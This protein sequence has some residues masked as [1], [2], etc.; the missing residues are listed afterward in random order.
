MQ[1]EPNAPE[2]S[3]GAA[4][5]SMSLLEHLDELRARLFR[6]VLGYFI[7]FLVCYSFH[8][9]VLAFLMAPIERHIE[10]GAIQNIHLPE[11]FVIKLKACGL[12]AVFVAAPWILLQVWGFIAPGMHR[13]EKR[14]VWPFIFFGSLFFAAGGAFGYMVALPAAVKWLL[15]MG[16]PYETNITLRSAFGF[17]TMLLLGMGAVFQLPIV[18][19]FL[20]RLGLVT[21]AFLMKN[22]RYAVLIMAI[23]AAVITPSGDWFTMSIVAGP[24]IVL[25]LLGV[26][27][28]WLFRRR[29]DKAGA[30]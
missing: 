11:A 23:V 3:T 1:S 17:E 16:A 5:G 20:S 8:E 15:E 19:F 9:Q 6:A 26:A 7:V 4:D 13:H 27:V 14:M 10:N 28:A 2:N 25:Y 21:P 30:T 22:F 29:N 12:L 24:M 18:I